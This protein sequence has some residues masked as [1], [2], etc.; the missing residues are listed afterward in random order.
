L[1]HAGQD[2]LMARQNVVVLTMQKVRDGTGRFD[3]KVLFGLAR[4][5]QLIAP[6]TKILFRP[7]GFLHTGPREEVRF[8]KRQGE[9]NRWTE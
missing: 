3:A 1:R 5:L 8:W 2:Y 6:V 4:Q 9:M 7:A